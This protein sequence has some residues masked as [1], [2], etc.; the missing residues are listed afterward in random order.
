MLAPGIALG[1]GRYDKQDHQPDLIPLIKT[2]RDVEIKDVV[3]LPETTRQLAARPGTWSLDGWARASYV[4]RSAPDG[5]RFAQRRARLLARPAAAQPTGLRERR[6]GVPVCQLQPP[7]KRLHRIRASTPSS[8]PERLV[9]HWRTS[10]VARA[11]PRCA[12]L[13]PAGLHRRRTS[14]LHNVITEWQ[15][16]NPGGEH[17]RGRRREII[18]RRPDRQ[19][20]DAPVR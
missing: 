19:H 13:H 16:T 20:A 2:R 10:E 3:R 7:R 14:T 11:I 8:R 1:G 6:R 12:E 18:P 4:L 5:R 17:L 15:A 9:L